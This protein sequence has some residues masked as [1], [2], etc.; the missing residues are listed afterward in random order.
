MDPGP[1]RQERTTDSNRQ[2]YAQTRVH[3]STRMQTKRYAENR[4]GVIKKRIGKTLAPGT[5]RA[6]QQMKKQEAE[7]DET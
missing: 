7:A 6:S 5:G 2:G 1:L 3:L 4:Q